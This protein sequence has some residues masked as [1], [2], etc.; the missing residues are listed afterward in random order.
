[1]T[2]SFIKITFLELKEITK[3]NRCPLYPKHIK[4]PNLL[5]RPKRSGKDLTI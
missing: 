4:Y 5:M 3:Q 1:M 2:S